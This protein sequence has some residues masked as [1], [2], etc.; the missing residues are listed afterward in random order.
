MPLDEDPTATPILQGDL[1]RGYAEM[2]P[3]GRWL[4]YVSSSQVFLQGFPDPGTLV[5]V[6][7]EGGARGLMWGP[8]GDRLY[9]QLGVRLMSATVDVTGDSARV[10]RPTEILNGDYLTGTLSDHRQ[11]DIAS[12]GRFLMMRPDRAASESEPTSPQV[13]LVQ[14]WFE[15]LK[16][17]VPIP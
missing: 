8:E 6:S 1:F 13:V 10:G 5:P 4:A 16:A 3:D 11:I 7:S 9:Y 12:D 17:R 2:S 14:N 15:E